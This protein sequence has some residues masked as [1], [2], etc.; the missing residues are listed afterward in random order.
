MKKITPGLILLIASALPLSLHAMGKWSDFFKSK[1]KPEIISKK[2]KIAF[3]TDELSA[4]F[5]DAL[6][7]G[8][9]KVVNQLGQVDGFNADP[10]IHIPLP[11]TMKKVKKALS[12]F[13]MSS[14]VNDLELKI[15]R[16]AELAAPKAKKL[17]LESIQNM[18]FEDVKTIYQGDTHSATKYF[19][20]KMT[21]TLSR[22]MKPVITDS[23]SEVGAIQLY[24]KVVKKYQGLPFVPDIKT[25]LTE[26]VV[27]KSMDGIFYYLA[28]QEEA[29]RKDPVKQ[30][31]NLLKKVFG[32]Q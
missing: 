14:M 30:T 29:I 31:T 24:D 26:Y 10:A 5:K 15:N 23:L 6:K 7:I 25:N 19:Q 8:S 2:Q 32:A 20:S 4:A 12:R 17:F 16:A 11:K 27:T 13:G 9:E 22:E 3:S 28:K 1:E 21:P 18:S